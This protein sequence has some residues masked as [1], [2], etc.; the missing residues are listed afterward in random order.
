[1]KNFKI[2]MLAFMLTISGHSCAEWVQ[3][4]EGSRGNG[5]N[6]KTYLD[7]QRVEKIEDEIFK[8][9]YL[10]VWTL[11]DFVKPQTKTKGIAPYKT[12]MT[13]YAIDC[14]KNRY[15]VI[16][17]AIYANKMGSGE[18][19]YNRNYQLDNYDWESP[20]PNSIGETMIQKVCAK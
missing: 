1:M 20:I 7:P 18:T 3:F 13:R 9:T 10:A 2:L 14:D 16:A 5:N 15:Q 4:A 6:Y 11:D 12:V 17:S 19:V 8:K